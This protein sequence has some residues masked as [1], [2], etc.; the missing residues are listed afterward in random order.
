[1]P[2]HKKASFKRAP[3]VLKKPLISK[4]PDSLDVETF[5]W[6]V[7]NRYIDCEHDIYG[8]QKVDTVD[9]LQN[10]IKK[11]QDFETRTWHDIKS[12]RRYNHSW[13]VVDLPRDLQQRLRER[14]LDLDE[15]FQLGLGGIPRIFGYRE[16][17]NFYLI[18]YDEKHG[19]HPT[20]AK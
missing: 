3:E 9:L 17:R 20:K 12:S 10:I 13:D 8:W 4:S 1:M 5:V 18:W 2:N 7:S 11:L 15:L 6:R 16:L 19:I 14:G